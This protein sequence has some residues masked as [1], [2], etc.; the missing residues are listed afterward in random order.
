MSSP[1]I[2]VPHSIYI[3]KIQS[4]EMLSIPQGR[5]IAMN[6][7]KRRPFH[8]APSV[9]KVTLMLIVGSA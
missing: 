3:V 7:A 2:G 8:V 9:A 1:G 5:V 4:M 6:H